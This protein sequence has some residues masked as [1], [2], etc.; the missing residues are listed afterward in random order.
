MNMINK[1]LGANWWLG[2]VMN[3]I[4]GDTQWPTQY[5]KTA[6]HC[7]FILVN[8]ALINVIKCYFL[9]VLTSPLINPLNT[10]VHVGSAS[11]KMLLNIGK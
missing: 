9:G 6:G 11:A 3:L 4:A 7:L 10:I 5:S 2:L 1:E 8:R